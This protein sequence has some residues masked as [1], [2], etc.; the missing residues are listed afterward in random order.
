MLYFDTLPKIIQTDNNGNSSIRT[1][2]MA[3]VSIIPEILKNPMLYYEYDVQDGDTPEIVAHK[4]YGD[5]YRYW[6]VLFANE[7][8]DPQWD[9]PLSYKQFNEYLAEKYPTTNVYN[10]VYQYEKIITQYDVTTATTTTE[11]VI[12][13]LTDYN[14]INTGTTTYELPTGDVV[15]TVSKRAV[16][17]YDYETELN[18]SKRKIRILNSFY[19]DQVETEFLKLMSQ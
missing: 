12:V 13:G 5:S 1:N 14:L 17:I 15:V 9:W 18:E 11:K 3:R 8:L 19:V 7:M 16:S 6:I 2:L 10:T 4:Y